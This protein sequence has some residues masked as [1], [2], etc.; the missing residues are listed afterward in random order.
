V[1][2]FFANFRRV[3]L[4]IRQGKTPESAISMGPCFCGTMPCKGIAVRPP[5]IAGVA[6]SRT[7]NGMMEL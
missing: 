4:L 7:S 5:A 2:A 1:R 3:K 6:L